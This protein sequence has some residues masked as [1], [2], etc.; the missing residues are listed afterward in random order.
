MAG[1]SV[2]FRSYTRDVSSTP[3]FGATVVYFFLQ[4]FGGHFGIPI[5]LLTLLA[6]KEVRRHP[7]VVNFLVSWVVYTTSFCLLLYSGSQIRANPPPALCAFQ[8]SMI[9]GASI[10]AP[11]AALAF[12]LNLFLCTRTV[13]LCI[14]D[15]EFA[16]VRK[17]E[18]RYVRLFLAAPWLGFLAC[19]SAMI[20]VSAFKI[21]AI[22][23][24]IMVITLVFEGIVAWKLY[25]LHKVSAQL[26]VLDD[27]PL[28]IVV[29][30]I[31]AT[32]YSLQATITC[33]VISNDTTSLPKSILLGSF[34]TA[35]FIV[36]GTQAD[37]LEVWGLT[38]LYTMV[39]RLA[40]GQKRAPPCEI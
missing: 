11:M 24:I 39:R 37:L 1:P 21:S 8:A 34:P 5:I 26:E 6:R 7:L 15:E 35:A 20:V 18:M 2:S 4:I 14:D 10:M 17:R 31:I 13:A 40:R 32:V 29:R 22:A 16:P 19:S 28:P 36:F 9:Y 38:K 30:A 12:V 27:C 33:L 25:R 3:S 23:G